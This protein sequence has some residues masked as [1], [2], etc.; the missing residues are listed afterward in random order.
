MSQI[1]G[2]DESGRGPIIGPLVMC[3]VSIDKK[4][5]QKLLNIGVKDSK[6][7]TEKK[8]DELEPQVKKIIK[9][10]KVIQVQADELDKLMKGGT[11][12]NRIE[13]LKTAMIIN[14]LE[15]DTAIIDCPST[16]LGA[17][18]R[19]LKAQLDRPVKLIVEHKADLNH[20]EV[21][22][23]SIIAKVTRDNEM[24]ALDA[25]YPG[26]GFSQ[27]KGYP[28]KMHI[29]AL[30]ELGVSSIHRKSFS[31]VKQLLESS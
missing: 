3:G 7:L 15:G 18:K 5:S 6:L 16:N 26:Y 4:N 27:H 10:F 19:E 12:L 21:S 24:V 23:A 8:R 31:P 11:N 22:A 13:L 17:Y 29:N 9:S 20:P 1:I 28:T 14:A 30:K 25:Q 2:I